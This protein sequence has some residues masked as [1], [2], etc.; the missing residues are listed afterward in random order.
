[1]VGRPVRASGFEWTCTHTCLNSGLINKVTLRYY[2]DYFDFVGLRLDNAFRW[3]MVVKMD[4][5][6]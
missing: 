2:M 1:M 4:R 5:L 3:V 6:R